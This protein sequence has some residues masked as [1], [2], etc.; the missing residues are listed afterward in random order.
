MNITQLL[1]QMG[2]DPGD[3]ADKVP[4]EYDAAL[5][6]ITSANERRVDASLR[7][8]SLQREL[9]ET[10]HFVDSH[11]GLWVTCQ[12]HQPGAEAFG[13]SGIARECGW[14]EFLGASLDGEVGLRAARK[15][16]FT[17]TEPGDCTEWECVLPPC[18]WSAG[19]ERRCAERLD[20]ARKEEAAAEAAWDALHARLGA[21]EAEATDLGLILH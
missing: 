7:L 2:F 14:A 13:P 16:G 5:G 18:R 6:R 15:L 12:G 21:L 20:A 19:Y 1:E 11:G 8:A 4:V 17:V 9:E 3:R 10:V